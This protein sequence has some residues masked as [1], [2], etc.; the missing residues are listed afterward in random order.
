MTGL[1]VGFPTR[2]PRCQG[3]RDGI[4][5][6]LLRRHMTRELLDQLDPS[7]RA[8]RPHGGSLIIVRKN[9]T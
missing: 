3:R 1:W 8:R 7:V 5:T 9:E 4:P 6:Y 2:Q